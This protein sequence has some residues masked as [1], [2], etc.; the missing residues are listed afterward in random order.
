LNPILVQTFGCRVN[1]AEGEA[2][3]A[4]AAG[5]GAGAM[6]IINGC[7]VTGEAM[8]QARQSARRA[9][10]ERPDARIVVTGCAAQIDADAFAAMPEV[11]AVIGD[12]EKLRPATWARLASSDFEKRM[13]GDPFAPRPAAEPPSI[14]EARTRAFLQIQN[15]CDHRCTFCVIPFARGGSRSV[16]PARVLAQARR[17]VA[18]GARE[19]VLTGVDITAYG[20]DLA[21][22]PQLGG[23][24]RR[25]LAELP[26]LTRLRLSSIDS[27]EADP[28]LIAAIGEEPRL[29]PH[30]HLSLQSGDDLILKRMKRRHSRAD[31]I[32]FCR[33]VRAMRP[34]VAFTADLIAGFPTEDE[35]M[36]ARSLDLIEECGLARVHA[37][38]YSAR[39]GT[40]A[41]RMPALDGA[42]VRERAARLR[43]A[44]EAAWARHLAG[45]V[46]ATMPALTERGGVA[47]AEDFTPMRVGATEPG[48]M[49][50]ARVSAS[51][52]RELTATLVGDVDSAA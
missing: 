52:G 16:E 22:A 2:M 10:R 17:V 26:A 32:A 29:M 9:R 34:D 24:V 36:F 8:R 51:D 27:I 4:L 33:R 39:P 7:A 30:F 38:P 13:V 21:A 14:A 11:D 31:A 20:A 45:K 48:E 3:A 19:I 50:E 28:E 40:P 49:R 18:E 15:G 42:L 41:A 6:T 23:L 12:A 37:F 44:S 46:G 5:A 1:L 43:E 25:L 35:A 47:R